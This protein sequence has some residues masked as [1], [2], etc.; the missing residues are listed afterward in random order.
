MT[1]GCAKDCGT[2]RGGP[3]RLGQQ[4]WRGFG[5]GGQRFCKSFGCMVLWDFWSAGVGDFGVCQDFQATFE[6]CTFQTF[7]P[8]AS[9]NRSAVTSPANP[10]SK[11]CHPGR[12]GGTCWGRGK[13]NQ[14]QLG[15]RS[16]GAALLSTRP[17]GPSTRRLIRYRGSTVSVEMTVISNAVN[18][19]GIGHGVPASSRLPPGRAFRS[20]RG[21]AGLLLPELSMR[22]ASAG[23]GC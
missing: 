21:P 15:S 14:P 3:L 2:V 17:A 1:T 11:L 9:A 8:P 23:S 6:I 19:G 18:A 7:P 13:E 22:R 4:L 12:S 10:D 5:P 20:L 16:V